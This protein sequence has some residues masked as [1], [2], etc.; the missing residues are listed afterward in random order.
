MM[1][2]DNCRLHQPNVTKEEAVGYFKTFDKES[3]L[4]QVIH[5]DD[6]T[7]QVHVNAK[8]QLSI[9]NLFHGSTFNK[10]EAGPRFDCK[11]KQFD[12]GLGA[13]AEKVK[14]IL[15]TKDKKNNKFPR[16]AIRPNLN[17]AVFDEKTAFKGDYLFLAVDEQL[18]VLA[19]NETGDV[20]KD[21]KVQ[22][23]VGEMAKKDDGKKGDGKKDDDKKDDEKKDEDDSISRMMVMDSNI[24][25]V[26][27]KKLKV[28]QL[29]GN[30]MEV[31][32]N[33]P[34]FKDVEDIVI[35]RMNGMRL[36][37]AK[38]A[39]GKFKVFTTLP[40]SDWNPYIEGV[41]KKDL[42]EG[43]EY[44]KIDLIEAGFGNVA[45]MVSTGKYYK[46]FLVGDS[47]PGQR[48]CHCQLPV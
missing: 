30:K 47:H 32:H 7:L 4:S 18:I 13:N 35:T 27:S 11:W 6:T 31:K 22:M 34:E 33:Y 9:C 42:F 26:K 14:K 24:M 10:T 12:L 16:Q 8:G 15:V 25:V 36:F 41:N 45:I 2:Q 20:Y 39:K 5:Y 19:V 3:K 29:Q 44:P 28:F 1:M 17:D 37:K 40:S 48:Q 23:A 38:G 46:Y 21:Y 43:E